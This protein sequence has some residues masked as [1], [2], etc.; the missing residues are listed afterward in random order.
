MTPPN[1]SP[2]WPPPFTP[3][4]PPSYAEPLDRILGRL[5]ERSETTAEQVG[6]IS[7]NVHAINV[8]LALGDKRMDH[9]Q[10]SIDKR[11]QERPEARMAGWERFVKVLAPY[12]ILP[13]AAWITGSWAVAVD[14]LR[15]L[16][17]K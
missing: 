9:L 17:G 12:I 15:A 4:P 13:L 14:I 10:R 6:H 7:T 11:P 5:L 16:A 3:T 2:V 1:G 8:R